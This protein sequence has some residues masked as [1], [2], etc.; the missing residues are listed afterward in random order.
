[1]PSPVLI[2][3]AIDPVSVFASMPVVY[4][5][6]VYA[7]NYDG[8][9]YALDADSGSQI[10]ALDLGSPVPSSPVL[11]NGMIVAASE[12]GQ[13]Y[14]IDGETQ[15]MSSLTDLEAKLLAPLTTDGSLVYA[16]TQENETIYALNPETRVIVWQRQ[17]Q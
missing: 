14:A 9:L 5:G 11:V 1:M 2:P 7:G 6:V 10:A 12:D 4:N 13:I 3:A 16:H 17:V 15:A 8:M